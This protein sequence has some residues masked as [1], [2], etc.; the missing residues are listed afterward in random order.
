MLT[1]ISAG[2]HR[3]AKSRN[4]RQTIIGELDSYTEVSASG[5][6]FHVVC[7][8]TL[9]E[10]FHIDRNPVEIYSGHINKLMALTGDIYDLKMT[11]ENSQE[12]LEQL[13]R[14][15]KGTSAPANRPPSL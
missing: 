15:M 13:L 4:G 3:R 9:E 7:R 11:I 14:K 5:E 10:D 6:G 8:G 2:M 12:K 1:S